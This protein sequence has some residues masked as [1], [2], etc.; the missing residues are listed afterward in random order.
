MC[1]TAHTVKIDMNDAV[2]RVCQV[3]PADTA[4]RWDLRDSETYSRID[5]ASETREGYL[6]YS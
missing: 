6:W 3:S 1:Q 2:L 4:V 5:A